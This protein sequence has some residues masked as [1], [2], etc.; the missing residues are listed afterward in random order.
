M[1]KHGRITI[2]AELRR[3]LGIVPGT[4]LRLEARDGAIY[5]TVVGRR[6]RKKPRS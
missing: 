1:D 5:I 3:R 6:P 4:R 2:P